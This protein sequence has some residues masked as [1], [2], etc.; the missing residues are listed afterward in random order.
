VITVGVNAYEDPSWDLQYTANDARLLEAALTKRLVNA[1]GFP[2]TNVVPVQLISD[3][4][5]DPEGNRVLLEKTATKANFKAVLDRLAGRE[6]EPRFLESISNLSKVQRV[7]P[8]DLVVIFFSSHGFRDVE[9]RFYL[10][11]FDIGTEKTEHVK[12][13]ISTDDLRSWMRQIDGGEM[14]LIIDACHAGAAVE[15]GGF[16]PGPFG[17]RGLGQLAYEKA[18]QVLGATQKETLA[19][20]GYLIHALVRD[21]LEARKANF[22]PKDDRITITEWLA[23]AVER[24][25]QLYEEVRQGTLDLLVTRAGEKVFET[26]GGPWD[27]WGHLQQPALFDFSGGYKETTQRKEVVLWER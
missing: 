13:S 16:K 12:K 25:P 21:G 19:R 5:S 22:Q 1:G 26:P 17:S 2:E 7:G 4:N 23:Y 11:P 10:A 27:A 8:E 3:W 24:V 9:G 15:E 6:V 18:M 14:V 20:D